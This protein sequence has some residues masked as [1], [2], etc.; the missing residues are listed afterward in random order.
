[1]TGKEKDL[2]RDRIHLLAVLERGAHNVRNEIEKKYGIDI[3]RAEYTRTL[4]PQKGKFTDGLERM[5]IQV[6]NGIE[7]MLETYGRE[8]IVEKSSDNYKALVMDTDVGIRIMQLAEIDGSF[9]PADE[10]QKQEEE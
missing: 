7:K 5:E 8:S 6:L 4:D 10:V 9:I 2:L 3:C 1:M